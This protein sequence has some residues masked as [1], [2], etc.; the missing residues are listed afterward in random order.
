VDIDA[1]KQRTRDAL[2]VFGDDARRAGAGFYRITIKAIGTGV[3]CNSK[4][5]GKL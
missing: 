4:A 5:D 2:L 3:Q 1:V